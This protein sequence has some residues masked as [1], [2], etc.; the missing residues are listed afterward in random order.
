MPHES[1]DQELFD[2]SRIL[3]HF[4]NTTLS[5]TSNLKLSLTET[6]VNRFSIGKDK[7]DCGTDT[8]S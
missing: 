1:Y 3:N 5:P 8:L 4:F 2:V 6:K 7:D